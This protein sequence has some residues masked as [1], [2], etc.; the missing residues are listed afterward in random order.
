MS[1]HSWNNAKFRQK[2]AEVND[3]RENVYLSSLKT[4]I[5]HLQLLTANVKPQIAVNEK[6]SILRSLMTRI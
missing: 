1:I 6:K 4:C 2:T 5:I 3:L